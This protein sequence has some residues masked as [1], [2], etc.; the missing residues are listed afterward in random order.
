MRTAFSIGML[1]LGGAA[2]TLARVGLA[3]LVQ[4]VHGGPW[5]WGTFVVN[6]AGCLIFGVLFGLLEAKQALSSV[7]ALALLAGF[8]GALT[9]FSTFAFDTAQLARGP[10][11]AHALGNFL[12]HGG[13]GL[14]LVFAGLALGQRL[15]G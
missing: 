13:V 5:P 6:A 10:G 9:T 8:C 15:G 14:V 7:A 12:L 11:F 4:R 1:A 3:E 2:G